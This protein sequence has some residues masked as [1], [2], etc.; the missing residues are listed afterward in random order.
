MRNVLITL[1]SLVLGSSLVACSVNPVTGEQVFVM[2]N[3]DENWERSVGKEMYAPMRQ[4]QGGDYILDS[5]LADY[6]ASVGDRLAAQA[7]RDLSYEFHVLNDSVP[8]AWA[9]PGG[10]IVVN[11]GLLTE[12]NSE[13]ELA[14][15]LGHEIVHAD[16]AHGARQQSKGMLTQV[17]MMA[18]MIYGSSK[19]DTAT[20]Q[21]IAM[22]LPQIGA[23]LIT[24][25][26][27]RDAERESDLYGMRY[28][29]AAGYDPK[30]AVE[31]QE[32]FVKLSEGRRS[33]W[34]S[35]MF[36]S[37]PPST[38]RVA[39]NRATAETLPKDGE[40]G[41]AVFAR[42][43][44]Y[45]RKAKPAYEA[46]DKARK[47]LA[48]DKIGDARKLVGQAIKLEPREAI[49]YAL[50]GDIFAS[51]DMLRQAERE[52]SEALKR[53][54]GFFYHYLRRG[55]IRYERGKYPAA[56]TDLER[57]LALLPTAQANLL[58]GNMDKLA[59]NKDTAV[60]YYQAASQ[61]NSKAGEE[62]RKELVLLE[63]PGDPDK[64]IQSGALL[65]KNGIVHAAVRNSSPVAVKAVRLKIEYIDA[66]NKLRQFSINVRGMLA[67]GEQTAVPTKI[68]DISDVN[69]LA[70]RVRVTVV[71]ARIAE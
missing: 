65:G 62:A 8:N 17:G 22:L 13:A 63:L 37:H 49:F 36:A 33:D 68:R 5:A 12:L 38:E 4:A 66:N 28:M 55:Q 6:V 46:H 27:G 11:R 16:A 32:T 24:T 2:P 54:D 58:L 53:D 10:K 42:K 56:H 45:I 70:R 71:G 34:L 64:Y 52:Y 18:A 25:K 43:T 14:A 50:S 21:Q 60:S 19:A 61:S 48:D 29:S 39:N 51:K 35:G 41:R 40:F 23:Q 7:K 15:V 30:G 20:E 47:A 67:A 26:Y 9:L 3:L 31:L 57:S 1:L 69:E 44:A 59:G